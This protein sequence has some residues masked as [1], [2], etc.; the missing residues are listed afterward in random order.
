MEPDSAALAFMSLRAVWK[1]A[2]AAVSDDDADHT[3]ALA[4]VCVMI[5]DVLSTAGQPIEGN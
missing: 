1:Y 5:A 4:D 2:D 3:V